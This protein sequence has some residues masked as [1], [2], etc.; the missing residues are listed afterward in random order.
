[1]PNDQVCCGRVALVTGAGNGIG[2]DT[3][4]QMAATGAM[5]W[6]NDLKE[7]LVERVVEEIIAA[8]GQAVGLVQNIAS[9]KA[10][11]RPS[12]ASRSAAGASTCW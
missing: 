3:A 5:V 11:A 8:G 12:W 1:M 2:R 6:V 4:R 9:A 7:E 10:C